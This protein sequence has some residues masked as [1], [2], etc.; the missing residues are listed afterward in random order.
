MAAVQSQLAAQPP[1]PPAATTINLPAPTIY[2]VDDC[3]DLNSLYTTPLTTGSN[4]KG[5]TL[6]SCSV[7]FSTVPANSTFSWGLYQRGA[8]GPAS[9]VASSTAAVAVTIP[10]SWATNSNAPANTVLQPNTTYDATYGK[11]PYGLCARE[12]Y[13]Q[14]TTGY[15]S[16]GSTFSFQGTYPNPFPVAQASVPWSEY[17]TVT[18]IQ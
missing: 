9:L 8:N 12:N 13:E 3:G 15:N 17:C 5:Y 10:N 2:P 18:P 4:A 11:S 6:N 7:Y 14:A 16:N 1:A